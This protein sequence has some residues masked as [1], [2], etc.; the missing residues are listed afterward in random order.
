MWSRFVLAQSHRYSSFINVRHRQGQCQI[1]ET[2][3][4]AYVCVAENTDPSPVD[5]ISWW[6][7]VRAQSRPFGQKTNIL[8]QHHQGF[9]IVT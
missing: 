8:S 3:S 4:I 6:K 9:G 5:R 7:V 2:S 1:A